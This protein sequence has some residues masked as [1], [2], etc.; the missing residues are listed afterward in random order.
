MIQK[1]FI[2]S[3]LLTA[4]S[5]NADC[6]HFNK[7]RLDSLLDLLAEKK[8]AM[9]SLVI[10]K[11]KQVIYS[12]AI[13]YSV[14]SEEKK[15]PASLNTKYRIGQATQMFTAAMIFQLIEAG[16]ITLSTTL[17][18]FWPQIPDAKEITIYNLLSHSSGLH[19]F[20][21]DPDYQT[22]STHAKTEK[23]LIRIIAKDTLDFP[24]NCNVAYSDANYL[25]LGY[26][27]QKVCKKPYAELLEH[28]ITS[29]A[30]VKNTFAGGRI[31]IANE[32]SVSYKYSNDWKETPQTDMT[33]AGGAGCIVSTPFDLV[34]LIE[35][36]FSSKLC[37]RS[38]LEQMKTADNDFKVGMGLHPVE[39][40]SRPGYGCHESIDG[41]SIL[42]FYFPDDS[43]A[44]AYCSN[45]ERY[46]RAGIFYGIVSACF[47]KNYS[48][49]VFDESTAKSKELDDYLGTYI[50]E[51]GQKFE[52]TKD[53]ATLIAYIGGMSAH[54]PLEAAGKDKFKF[55]FIGLEFEFD[56]NDGVLIMQLDG[57]TYRLLK[58]K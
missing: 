3:L 51:N 6:Q 13:G 40:Y 19:N 23:E 12:R 25:L 45:A 54:I 35:A 49:P 58:Q 53:Q 56:P 17:D 8:E 10:S 57:H 50:M 4:L 55:E 30:G 31:N 47:D 32:E 34:K 5:F 46:L 41:F 16:H 11:N 44:I 43:L 52:I 15:K 7:S 18:T 36:L 38:S 21:N 48:F 26:I 29:K 9:G 33:V 27:L 37:S 22:W 24:P 2:I 28:L 1:A 20:A 42:L 14:I 39:L